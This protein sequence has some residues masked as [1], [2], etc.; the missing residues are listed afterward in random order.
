MNSLNRPM[1]SVICAKS[2]PTGSPLAVYALCILSS[3]KSLISGNNSK[4]FV[5][6]V[7]L[8]SHLTSMCSHRSKW[9][10]VIQ[11]MPLIATSIFIMH[12]FLKSLNCA[13]FL[14]LARTWLM[15]YDA[16]I[17][18]LLVLGL[19]KIDICAANWPFNYCT[20]CVCRAVLAR[21]STYILCKFPFGKATVTLQMRKM[22]FEFELTKNNPPPILN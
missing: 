4:Q 1:R 12:L 10:V 18:A 8:L 13:Y 21:E 3:R 20:F 11:D 22:V 5:K 7:T 16:I 2:K 6:N 17:A 9:W 19:V 15:R 14:C